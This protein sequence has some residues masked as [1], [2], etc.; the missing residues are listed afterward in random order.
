M[1]L[2]GSIFLL[3]ERELFLIESPLSLFYINILVKKSCLI[4]LFTLSSSF[5]FASPFNKNIKR[6]DYSVIE[7][8]EVLIK[9]IKN[10]NKMGLKIG[11]SKTRDFLLDQIENLNPKY[12]AEIIQVKPYKGNENLPQRLE[13]LLYNISEYIN[14]PYYSER[15]KTTT[16]LYTSAKITGIKEDGNGMV[17]NAEFIMNPFGKVVEEIKITRNSDAIYYE[18]VNTMPLYLENKIECIKESCMKSSIILFRDNEDWVLYAVGGVNAPRI[19]FLNNRVETAFIN[20][21]KS[22]CHYMF[23][24]L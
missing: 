1:F 22:F 3:V 18:A 4:L 5:L 12:L 17:I 8:G 21:I 23:K 7:S 14:I 24:K 19:P 15:T 6:E 16:P 20:R 2:F 10:K 11:E 13:S 9:N